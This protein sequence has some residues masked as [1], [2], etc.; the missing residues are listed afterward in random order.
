MASTVPSPTIGT[1]GVILPPQTGTGVVGDGSILT[2]VLN[3]IN[4]AFGGT[5]NVTQPE[6]LTTPQGQLASSLTAYIA[7]KNVLFAYFV[8]QVNPQYAQG[9]MQDGIA[10]I[11][12]L[13]RLPATYTTVTCT[14]TGA[15]GTVI[16]SG[17]Q[18]Q[19]VAGNLYVTSTG[20]TIG[21]GNTVSIVFNCVTPGAIQ[22]PA[23]TLIQIMTTTPG[24]DSITNPTGTDT[25]PLTI[26]SD[27]ESASDFEYR[28]QQSVFLNAQSPTQSIQAAVLAS[29]ADLTI[30]NIPLDCYV[31]DNSTGTDTYVQGVLIPAHSVFVAVEGG[32]PS[33]IATAIWQKKAV[34]CAYAPSA[35]FTAATDTGSP[36]LTVTAIASGYIQVGQTV[37]GDFVPEGTTISAFGTGT[38]GLGTYILSANATGHGLMRPMT[39]T[40]TALVTDY[41]YSTLPRPTYKVDYTIAYQ[42]PIYVTVSLV[43]SSVDVTTALASVQAAVEGAFLGEDGGTKARIG[44]TIYGSRFYPPILAAM[45]GAQI[46]NITVGRNAAPTAPY[47]TP[48]INEYPI[49]GNAYISIL[50]V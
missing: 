20:G 43:A 16:P 40:T 6:A 48:N 5:L 2:A 22:C 23:S 17:A 38:G 44:Q 21:S 45:P 31:T 41:S 30:P 46:T 36:T 8:S 37:T 39:S 18:A 1:H 3:D 14:C 13:S 7:D 11:F 9:F 10:A 34:G 24:W 29:G 42:L 27:L 28:R 19:D 25:D 15:A 32:D 50:L 26:G 33:S 49:T 12:G 47:V 4:T 35:I